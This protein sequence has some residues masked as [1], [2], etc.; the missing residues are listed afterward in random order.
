MILFNCNV[1]FYKIQS[2]RLF[3][4]QKNPRRS[5]W[6]ID[7]PFIT[8]D[9]H[10]GLVFAQPRRPARAFQIR[11][12]RPCS[13]HTPLWPQNLFIFPHLSNLTVR[14]VELHSIAACLDHNRT[15]V[16]SLKTLRTF[17]TFFISIPPTYSI[18]S[19]NGA[20]MNVQLMWSPGSILFCSGAY[21]WAEKNK[22]K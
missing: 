18:A 3:S 12:H 11:P 16:S 8:R 21:S 15:I 14:P 22:T 10:S 17:S 20:E 1:N 5:K 2:V 13:R 4:K 7:K 6:R 9:K 19:C